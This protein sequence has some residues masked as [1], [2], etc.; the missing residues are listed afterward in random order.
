MSDDGASTVFVSFFR[1]RRHIGDVTEAKM[2]NYHPDGRHL[3]WNLFRMEGSL[4]ASYWAPT[5]NF[6]KISDELNE[7]FHETEWYACIDWNEYL[8]MKN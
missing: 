6:D 2:I 7:I 1:N 5:F 8:E 3:V 4:V